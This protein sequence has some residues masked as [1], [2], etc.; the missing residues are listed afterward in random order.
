MITNKEIILNQAETDL[1]NLE[2]DSKAGVVTAEDLEQ[3]KHNLIKKLGIAEAYEKDAGC[4]RRYF[5]GDEGY[6]EPDGIGGALAAAQASGKV[7]A[8][9]ERI[10]F[11][12]ERKEMK[13]DTQSPSRIYLNQ[14]EASCLNV[15][16]N[17][18]VALISGPREVNVIFCT[19]CGETRK[20]DITSKA[21]A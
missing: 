18:Q 19:K 16:H 12:K 10:R 3:A 9:A 4:I 6:G 1:K 15:G 20:L 2:E 5:G 7:Y 14:T 17:F 21:A 11:E 8:G 13:P